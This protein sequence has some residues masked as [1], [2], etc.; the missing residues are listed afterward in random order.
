ML[1]SLGRVMYNKYPIK[2]T[3]TIKN[4]TGNITSISFIN[5]NTVPTLK[6]GG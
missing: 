1:S 2:T 4:H 6:A 3:N 5:P